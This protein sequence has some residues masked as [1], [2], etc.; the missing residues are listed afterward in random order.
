MKSRARGARDDRRAFWG[1][2]DLDLSGIAAKH[3]RDELT[4]RRA[5]LLDRTGRSDERARQRLFPGRQG[6]DEPDSRVCDTLAGEHH[7][8]RLRRRADVS[9]RDA[10]A[11]LPRAGAH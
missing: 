7:S 10:R 11:D 4:E 5:A 1:M 3:P 9:S 8:L 6:V 2:L